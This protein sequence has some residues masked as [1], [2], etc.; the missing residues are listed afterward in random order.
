MAKIVWEFTNQRK[1]TKNEF[2]DY[3]EKKVFK[4]I[5]KYK[6][7]PNERIFKIKKSNDI[8][9]IILKNIL[10]QKFKVDFSDNPNI[11]SDNLSDVAEK[12]FENII[13]GNF[14]GP[15]Q[16]N[17]GIGIPLYYHSDKEIEVYAELRRINGQKKKRNKKIQNL[18]SKFIDKN[19]DLEINIV[20]ALGQLPK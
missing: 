2:I 16:Q 12:I 3:F 5:R 4:T 7:L 15:L 20:K 1:L 13:D 18:F 14:T 17:K 8:N 9:T 19:Q 11:I 6:L 10:E